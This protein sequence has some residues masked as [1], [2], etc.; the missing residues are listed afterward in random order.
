MYISGKGGNVLPYSFLLVVVFCWV[1]EWLLRQCAEEERTTCSGGWR[2][3]KKR[4]YRNKGK[5]AFEEVY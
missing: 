5:K 3:K 2:G 4:G 1:R